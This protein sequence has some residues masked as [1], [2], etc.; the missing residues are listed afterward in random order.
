MSDE[1]FLN[2]EQIIP[3]PE[4]KEFMI[5]I[6]AKEAEETQ[7]KTVISNRHKTRPEFWQRLLQAFQASECNLFN[8]ID[9]SKD[10]W[11][12][13]TTGVAGC[14]YFMVFNKKHIRV[15]M[16]IQVGNTERNKMLFDK[17]KT[18]DK[19]INES[20]GEPLTWLRQDNAKQSKVMTV[21][22]CDAYDIDN[23]PELIEWFVA[24]TIKF[25]NTFSHHLQSVNKQVKAV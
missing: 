2:V 19:A 9:P 5:G 7:T 1:L 8:N 18:D 6:N 23:W 14:G 25:E 21:Y 11:I 13:A 15:E 3:T 16:V 24:T 20:F 17:L 12:A 10:N 4:A 22:D